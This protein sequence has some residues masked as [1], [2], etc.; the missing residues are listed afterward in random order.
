[1]KLNQL[2][3]II[4]YVQ[5]LDNI[6]TC[7]KYIE[8]VTD[9]DQIYIITDTP[10]TSKRAQ[11]YVYESNE[12]LNEMIQTIESDHNTQINP[13]GINIFKQSTHSPLNSEF[14][15]FQRSLAVLLDSDDREKV[16][17]KFS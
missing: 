16:K 3:N 10:Y 5:I 2:R 7:N 8:Q 9:D 4:D 6:D 14:L 13:L 12:N 1:M 15:W 17:K 11:V